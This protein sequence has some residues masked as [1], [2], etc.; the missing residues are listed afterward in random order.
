M[1][2]IGVFLRNHLGDVFTFYV[3]PIILGTNNMEKDNTFLEGLKHAKKFFFS[4]L[5]IEGDSS[6][7]INACIFM[8][9]DN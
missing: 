8:N 6:V 9:S 3:A 7:I 2:G 4:Y 5:H 1:L